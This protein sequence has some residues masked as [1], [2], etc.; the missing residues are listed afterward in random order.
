MTITI[1]L[2]AVRFIANGQDDP[3]SV[4]L[5]ECANEIERLRKENSLVTEWLL[6]GERLMPILANWSAMFFIGGWW[7]DRPWRNRD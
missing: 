6:E 2:E 7:A 4:A 1:D 5:R 3:K